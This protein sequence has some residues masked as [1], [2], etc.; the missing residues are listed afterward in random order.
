MNFDS[1]DALTF[2]LIKFTYLAL[3]TFF[4][5]LA[6]F[7]WQVGN[8]QSWKLRA[9]CAGDVIEFKDIF[10]QLQG[11]CSTRSLSL[12]HT[13]SSYLS[14]L[15]SVLRKVAI[16][17]AAGSWQLIGQQQKQ[18]KPAKQAKTGKHTKQHAR[19]YLNLCTSPVCVFLGVCECV[20]A[21]F[22]VCVP[23]AVC[24]W[25]NKYKLQ[26]LSKPKAKKK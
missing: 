17:Y 8:A 15:M 9:I 16:N 18:P 2:L 10:R 25:Q 24:S 3:L 21:C 13:L 19:D 6:K 4:F 20:R 11:A 5:T 14:A 23:G 12:S 22:C 1:P 7:S 26:K